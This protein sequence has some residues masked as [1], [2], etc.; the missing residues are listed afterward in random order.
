MELGHGSLVTG[1][2][3]LAGSGRVSV[4]D[5]VFDLVL[6]FNMFLALFLRVSP[7]RHHI[8]A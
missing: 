6:N 4:S 1:S 5:P 3:I 7:S 2:A 8:S